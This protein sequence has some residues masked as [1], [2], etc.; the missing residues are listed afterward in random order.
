[1]SVTSRIPNGLT[2]R[3]PHL[4]HYYHDF[5]HELSTRRPLDGNGI[6]LWDYGFPFGA[7]YHPV[8]LGAY[9][10]ALHES[11]L[12]TGDPRTQQDC[13]NLADF[14]V[15]MQAASV[16]GFGWEYDV[17]DLRYALSPPWVSGMAQGLAISALLRAHTLS[18]KSVY[19][20]SATRA[21]AS[22]EVSAREGGCREVD[23]LGNVWYEETP[24]TSP[25]GSAHILNGFLF[26]IWGLYDYVRVT[27][28]VRAG[29]LYELGIKTLSAMIRQYDTGYWTRYSLLPRNYLANHT[30]HGMHINGARI[31]YELTGNSVFDD[32]VK[33]W[34]RYQLDRICVIEARV[35]MKAYRI[36]HKINRLRTYARFV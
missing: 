26:A 20:E 5:T 15:T 24:S 1:M 23:A 8:L 34:T 31:F 27:N 22:F 21:L 11:F 14:L 6:P 32:C 28:D 25:S 9:T 19:L 12:Q 4:D 7:R 17:F 13:L 10:L 33:Q 16:T 30:Y 2:L 18:P 29:N 36:L 3:G 35:V